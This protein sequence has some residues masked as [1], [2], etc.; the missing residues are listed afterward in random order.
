M[1]S[2]TREVLIID[3]RGVIARDESTVVRH[4][5]YGKHL[6][7]I[8][9]GETSLT[10]ITRGATAQINKQ[11]TSCTSVCKFLI[12]ERTR[13]NLSRFI[14]L[15]FNYIRMNNSRVYLLVSGDPWETFWFCRFLAFFSR[16]NL[17]IQ[18]Q[19]HADIF[20][21]NWIQISVANRIR[22]RL[23]NLKS[24]SIHNVRLVSAN[25]RKK[26]VNRFPN[27]RYRVTVAPVPL[28]IS[29]YD[30]RANVNFSD[31]ATIGFVGRIH[32]DR[33]LFLFLKV[34]RRLNQDGWKGRVL[35]VGEGPEMSS[36]RN[37]LEELI[38]ASRVTF[39]GV[40]SGEELRRCWSE[41]DVFLNTAPTESYG[42][43]TREA[44]YYGKFVMSL[45]TRGISELIA[46]R[47]SGQ[48]LIFDSS[49]PE[50]WISNLRKIAEFKADDSYSKRVWEQNEQDMMNVVKSWDSN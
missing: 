25:H 31:E 19:L 20:D 17:K 15:C 47:E 48:L 9:L 33:G 1:S 43:S 37:N 44:L 30:S 26:L 35:V 50:S 23:L 49:K 21:P 18:V 40:K 16:K 45:E 34:I 11:L 14:L 6:D 12:E 27:L 32:K 7:Q 36:F 10:V 42:R 46:E 13:F 24:E 39:A 28:S 3:L 38:G 5:E 8:S 2:S 22:L 4:V 41:I 29:P